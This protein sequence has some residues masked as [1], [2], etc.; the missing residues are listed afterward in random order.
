MR[1]RERGEAAARGFA[2]S[3]NELG[4]SGAGACHGHAVR[5]GLWWRWVTVARCC[6]VCSGCAVVPRAPLATCAR[7]SPAEQFLVVVVVARVG[8]G[9]FAW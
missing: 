7:A 3:V 9:G 2:R 1:K 8:V 4:L 5:R 6:V